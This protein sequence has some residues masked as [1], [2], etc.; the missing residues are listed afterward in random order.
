MPREGQLAHLPRTESELLPSLWWSKRA[1]EKMGGTH[2][3][4][5]AGFKVGKG[6]ACILADLEG[7]PLRLVGGSTFPNWAE[8]DAKLSAPGFQ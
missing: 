4:H 2:P 8:L 1:D 6:I 5:S 3:L 7:R